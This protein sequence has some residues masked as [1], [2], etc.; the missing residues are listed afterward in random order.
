MLTCPEFEQVTSTP[1]PGSTG[2]GSDVFSVPF[3]SVFSP[4]HF[5]ESSGLSLNFLT[6]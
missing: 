5:A 6:L 3:H 2:N 1:V 4:V